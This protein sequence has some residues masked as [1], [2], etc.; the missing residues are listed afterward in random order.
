MQVAGT[1]V[2]ILGP[3]A[4]AFVVATHAAQ[5]EG[6]ASKAGE[7]LR[8]AID[9]APLEVWQEAARLAERLHATPTMSVGLSLAPGGAALADRLGLVNPALARAATRE[10]SRAGMAIGFERL[11]RTNGWGARLRLIKRELF[12]SRD[13]IYGW[14]S[15]ARRG[16][17]GTAAVYLWRPVWLLA[18][19]VPGLVA[20]L[21]HRDGAPQ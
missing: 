18:S 4:R 16:R 1:T 13:F 10:G 20:W 15:L 6:Q 9:K 17:R 2:K 11:A 14:S 3:A 5:H 19:A 21:R 7:D 8:R 12:P